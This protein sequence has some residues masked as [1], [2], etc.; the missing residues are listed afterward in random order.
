MNISTAQLQ[1]EWHLRIIAR[2]CLRATNA[3]SGELRTWQR[4]SS[5]DCTK[6][7]RDRNPWEPPSLKQVILFWFVWAAKNTKI[8]KGFELLGYFQHRK[9]KE[10]HPCVVLSLEKQT[11]CHAK[12]LTIG[13]IS[14]HTKAH[15]WA[16]KVVNLNLLSSQGNNFPIS[17]VSSRPLC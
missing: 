15:A 2:Y 1:W 13:Q 4:C 14:W 7:Q 5:L 12:L 6:R 9:R 11:H 8:D 3:K 10:G 17:S 16:L